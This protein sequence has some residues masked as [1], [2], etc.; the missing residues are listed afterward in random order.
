MISEKLIDL[1]KILKKKDAYGIVFFAENMM[2]E[3]Q[4]R[5]ELIDIFQNILIY[6]F[7]NA[8]LVIRFSRNVWGADIEKLQS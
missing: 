6:R 1:S 8:R 3:D 5:K 7:S 2:V 4:L